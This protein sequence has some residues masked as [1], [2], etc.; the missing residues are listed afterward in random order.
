MLAPDWA[1]LTAA[2]KMGLLF[3]TGALL[4]SGA[5]V[6]GPEA[7]SG[8][9]NSFS[10]AA[11]GGHGAVLRAL[12]QSANNHARGLL[13]EIQ[14]AHDVARLGDVV[15]AARLEALGVAT[16]SKDEFGCGVTDADLFFMFLAL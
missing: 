14:V 4:E 5:S 6:T 12:L 11:K 16:S 8:S 15:A 3:V 9:S 1:P 13:E 2:A 10:A 7:K